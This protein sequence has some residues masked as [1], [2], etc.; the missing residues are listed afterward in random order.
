MVAQ[1]KLF[2]DEVVAAMKAE[3]YIEKWEHGKYY[4][5]KK[6]G[7]PVTEAMSKKQAE[8]YMKLLKKEE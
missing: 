1:K 2:F 6:G 8:A 7:T 5:Y 4:I 3:Y